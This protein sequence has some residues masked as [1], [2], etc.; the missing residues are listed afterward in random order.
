MCYQ[1][2][3]LLIQNIKC[4]PQRNHNFKSLIVNIKKKKKER[5]KSERNLNL[6]LKNTQKKKERKATERNNKKR[7][8]TI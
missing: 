5:K 6:A 7:Q 2:K 8:K 3:L 4:E 1:L